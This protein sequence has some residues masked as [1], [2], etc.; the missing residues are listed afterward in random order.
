MPFGLSNC[1]SVFQALVNDVLLEM[2]NRC[3]FVYL[4]DIL[5]FSKDLESHVQQVRRVLNLLWENK[6]FVKLEKC[7]FH[8]S[9]RFF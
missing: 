4:D 5:V 9:K 6:L 8:V 1:P 3:V 7:Q 2:I